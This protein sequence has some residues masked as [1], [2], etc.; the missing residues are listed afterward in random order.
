MSDAPSTRQDHCPT[1]FGLERLRQGELP[2][3][4]GLGLHA[5][6]CA[7]CG[8]R[9]I[10]LAAAPPALDLG[11]TWRRGRSPW[12][13]RRPY[14]W[15]LG[16]V[17]LAATLAVLW[18]RAP[19]TRTKGGAWSLSL[20]ART[21]DGKVS[22]IAPGAALRPGDRLRFEIATRWRDG[23]AVLVGLD[24][25]GAVS[26][27]VPPAGDAVAVPAGRRVLLDG[28]VELDDTMGA[29]QILLVGCRRQT[30]VASV[31]DAAR[32][33]LERAGGDP[34]RVRGLGLDCDE[35]V[36]WINKVSR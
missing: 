28:A 12:P 11:E 19:D 22:R 2:G 4:S 32:A 6:G 17:A 3:D 34:R 10:E 5:R 31:L 27:L 14:R 18:F 13:V 26:P 25:R 29:E 33:A 8:A 21:S 15:W 9:L 1:D 24:S 30:S 20:V 36:F 7:A 16:A 35:T 23:H